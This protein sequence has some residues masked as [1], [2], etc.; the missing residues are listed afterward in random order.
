MHAKGWDP[1]QVT[2]YTMSKATL[3]SSSSEALPPSFATGASVSAS[4]KIDARHYL[5][6]FNVRKPHI[7]RYCAGLL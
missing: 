4:F 7:L 2:S 1:G 6:H 5:V 3:T